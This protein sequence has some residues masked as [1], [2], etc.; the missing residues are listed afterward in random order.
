[1]C[2]SS[3]DWTSASAG[4]T[5][6]APGGAFLHAGQQGPGRNPGGGARRVGISE[7]EHHSGI[8]T[9]VERRVQAGVEEHRADIVPA[10]AGVLAN[11]QTVQGQV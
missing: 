5:A 11:N 2:A 1:M 9:R 6:S 3:I 4:A 8:G 7:R 10:A